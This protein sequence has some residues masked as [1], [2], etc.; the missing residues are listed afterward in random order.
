MKVYWWLAAE[1]FHSFDEIQC[2]LEGKGSVWVL[3]LAG[4]YGTVE[5]ISDVG[6]CN[7]CEAVEQQCGAN[8]YTVTIVSELE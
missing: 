4:T 2:D 8:T 7:Y 3:D 6:T 1:E 5:S